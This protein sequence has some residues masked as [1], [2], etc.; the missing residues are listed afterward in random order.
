M[1]SFSAVAA[2]QLPVRLH[3]IQLGRPVDL[4]VETEIWH[5]LGFVVHCGDEALRFL[6]LGASQ[7]VEDEIAVASALLLLEDVAFYR[8][9]GASLR[10]LLG[11]A[12]TRGARPIGT[13]RDLI[14]DGVRV[15][16]LA[17]E[18][19]RSVGHVPPEGLRVAPTRASAA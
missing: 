19:G 11:G 10:A 7:P 8:S 13:L 18:R 6:P 5:A 3:G 1:G 9:R 12:V 17:V 14:V 2:L 4:L 15:D 16:Q